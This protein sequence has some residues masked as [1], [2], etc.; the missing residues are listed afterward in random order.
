MMKNQALGRRFALFS[1]ALVTFSASLLF[2]QGA[3]N[4]P[5]VV[6]MGSYRVTAPPE[7]KWKVLLADDCPSVTFTKI[8]DSLLA[9]ASG[10][11]RGTVIHVQELLLEPA[12]WRMTEEQAAD[13]FLARSIRDQAR[14]YEAPG[15]LVDRGE[16]VL[17]DKKVRFLIFRI[18]SAPNGQ[19]LYQKSD[20]ALFVYFP[21][22]FA[23][24]HTFYAFVH[25]FFRPSSGPVK[26]YKRP[27][28]E[29]VHAVIES[30]EIPDPLEGVRGRGGDILRA[31]AA[32][33]VEAVNGAI[34][35]GA[36]VDTAVPL[37]TPLIAAAFY[38]RKEIID[39]LLE[40][41]ADINRSEERMGAAPLV[42]AI[43]AGEPEI[44]SYLIDLGADVNHQTNDG[45]SALLFAAAQGYSGLASKL[46]EKGAVIDT[47]TAH[48]ETPLMFA[49]DCGSVETLRILASAGADL[50]AETNS[51]ETPLM[52]AAARGHS[53]AALWLLEN[54]AKCDHQCAFGRTPLWRAIEN[55]DLG[56][57]RKLIEAGAPI[58]ARTEGGHTAIMMAAG[59]GLTEFVS[60][61]IDAGADVNAMADKK[62]TALK[63]AKYKK[64]AEIVKLL[65][66]AGA[67]R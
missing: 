44:A 47:G 27:G 48:G 67:K 6:D 50:N 21:P 29:S 32:G 4:K 63:L 26:L 28:L 39:L 36:S 5:E 38:G 7:G 41:G 11:V 25:Q 58:D 20:V 34:D 10:Q 31:A 45:S 14:D 9:Q 15:I 35:Q 60:L 17:K 46:I 13:R 53:E 66:A 30:L 42:S 18:D 62:T 65:K 8:R 49:S 54:G 22:E 61:L 3:G 33:S 51:G 59:Y 40:K 43:V 52:F 57:A 19:P 64:N 1:A 56:L 55:E 37:W 16:V 12:G 2:A 24:F 23:K